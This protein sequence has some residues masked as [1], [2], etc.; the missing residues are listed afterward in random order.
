MKLYSPDN[1]KRGP[2]TANVAGEAYELT[3]RQTELFH[4]TL[5]S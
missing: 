1:I 3:D 2:S 5:I 4:F